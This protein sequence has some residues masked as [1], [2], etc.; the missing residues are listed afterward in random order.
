MLLHYVITNEEHDFYLSVLIETKKML[1][2][3][4][5]FNIVGFITAVEDC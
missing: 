5:L 2:S 1:M 3:G 4:I